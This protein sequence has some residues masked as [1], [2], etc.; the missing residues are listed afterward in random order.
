MRI[1]YYIYYIYISKVKHTNSL[2]Q[3]QETDNAKYEVLFDHAIIGGILQFISLL[4]I[5]FILCCYH[6][7]PPLVSL[8]FSF[9]LILSVSLYSSYNYLYFVLFFQNIVVACLIEVFHIIMCTILDDVRGLL[10][11]HF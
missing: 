10:C 7:T 5:S 11:T 3:D 8:F 4:F 9:F 1:L 6:A 2:A